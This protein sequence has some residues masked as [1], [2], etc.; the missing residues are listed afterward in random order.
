V[1]EIDGQ[2]KVNRSSAVVDIKNIKGIEN[3][4]G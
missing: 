3:V 1:Y 4:L 2:L